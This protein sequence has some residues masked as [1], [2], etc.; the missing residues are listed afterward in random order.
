M[1]ILYVN[2]GNIKSSSRLLI[3]KTLRR[4]GYEVEEYDEI[5]GMSGLEDSVVERL[6]LSIRENKIDIVL[7]LFFIM[8]TALATYHTNTPY[9]SILWDAPYIVV[10]NVLAKLDHVWFSTFDKLEKKRFLEY[11]IP[12]V[13]YQPLTVSKGDV[14]EWNQEIRETLQGNYIHEISFVGRLYEENDYDAIID[15]IPVNMQYYFNSIF[16]EAAFKWDGV[17][18]IYGQTGQEIL[19]YIK[20]INPNFQIPDFKQ[21]IEEVRHFEVLYLIRKLANIE[22]VAIL[23]LLAEQ[24]TVDFYTFSGE[25]A[26]KVLRNVNIRLPVVY[27]KAAALVYAGS[28]INLNISLKGIE[29]GTPQR[30]MDIMGAGGFVLSSYCEETAELFE[31]D[32]EIVMFRTPEEMLDK[33]E[34]YLSHERERE[35]IARAGYEKVIKCF[36]YEKKLG[37]LLEWVRGIR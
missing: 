2:G 12:H 19:D 20:M 15:E 33:I 16:E 37:E 31:E 27:G 28:K 22:R 36:T 9:V 8:N 24:Y 1:K 11:G 5:L 18:R 35:T 17:N 32:K 13:L 23:N 3:M 25:T 21:D 10:Y 6:V 4:I 34:F 7:S 14:V 30:V 29:G 26:Q